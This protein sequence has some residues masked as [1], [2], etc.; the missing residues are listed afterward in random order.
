[1]LTCMEICGRDPGANAGR[2]T[3]TEEVTLNLCDRSF[4]GHKLS[5]SAL[6]ALASCDMDLVLGK[7]EFRG[8]EYCIWG[9]TCLHIFLACIFP[10]LSW[11]TLHFSQ[12][13]MLFNSLLETCVVSLEQV[14]EATRQRLK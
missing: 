2:D 6:L 3:K 1:M 10:S 11:D 8:W 7:S 14:V 5:V 4:L 9:L 12:Q 13:V